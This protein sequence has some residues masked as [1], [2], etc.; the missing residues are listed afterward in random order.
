MSTNRAA[1]WAPF[2]TPPP[3]V[4]SVSDLHF[5]ADGKM[6]LSC[7]TP[8]SVYTNGGVWMSED[9]GQSW[10]QIFKTPWARMTKTA[11]YD[12][13]VIL[14][15]MN[16]S[17]LV[18]IQ[19]PGTYLSRDGG[20]TWSR[21][22]RGNPQSDRVNDLAIDQVSSNVYYVS[23]YGAGW[24]RGDLI[25]TNNVAPVLPV[26]PAAHSNAVPLELYAQ[27]VD[28]ATDANGDSIGYSLIFG[29]DWLSVTPDGLLSATPPA[30]ALGDYLFQVQADDGNGMSSR[31]TMS[32]VVSTNAT[33]YFASWLRGFSGVGS[34]DEYADDPDQDGLSNLVEYGLGG[35]PDVFD[36]ADIRPAFRSRGGAFEYVY[37]RRKD[38]GTRGICYQLETTADLVSG[39]W[40]VFNPDATSGDVDTVFMVVTTTIPATG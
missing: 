20:A 23:T 34:F 11:L 14:V 19:N 24:L 22:N 27:P 28:E 4:S 9:G 7:G 25:D 29:P 17:N 15:Q 32:M 8:L 5:A 12:P 1:S 33:A 3:G 10:I 21:I 38:A 31:K 6:Y 37:H 18:D 16:G 35:D 36:S 30:D 26:S 39:H 13:N 2:P 40:T